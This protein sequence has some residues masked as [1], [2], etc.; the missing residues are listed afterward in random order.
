MRPYGTLAL[1]ALIAVTAA[2]AIFAAY[3]TVQSDE[4]YYVYGSA[5]V[6]HEPVSIQANSNFALSL[7]AGD[8]GTN[9]ELLMTVTKDGSIN[10]V[11]I[12]VK[13]TNVAQLRGYF[14]YL[15]ILLKDST[16]G[17]IKGMITLNKPTAVLT[18]DSQDFDSN[19]NAEIY[20]ITYY[21]LADHKLFDNVPLL[22]QVNLLQES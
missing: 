1:A 21:E 9:K 19:G 13:L 16:S 22:F 3:A 7:A 15:K 5:T 8:Q 6:N 17:E 20:A 12:S 11:K 10:S 18:L 14:K 2:F 4:K